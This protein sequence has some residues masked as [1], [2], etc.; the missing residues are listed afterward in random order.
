MRRMDVSLRD[1]QDN[2]WETAGDNYTVGRKLDGVVS[3]IFDFGAFIKFDD[4]IEGLLRTEDVDWT[5]ASLDLKQKFKKGDKLQVVVLSVDTHKEKLRLGIKQLSDNPFKTFSMNY[6]KGAPVTCTVK[7]ILDNGITVALQ[8][9]LEVY[10]HISNIDKENVSK[11][12][13]F[14]KVGDEIHAVVKFVDVAKSKIELSRKE[15][16]LKADKLEVEQFI[17]NETHD[18][19]HSMTMGS[20]L[21]D[22]FANIQIGDKAEEKKT[23]KKAKAEKTEK[24]EKAEDAEKPAKKTSKKKDKEETEE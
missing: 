18:G 16:L 3:S 5:E 19:S 2:P 6:P 15:F 14:V 13:D 10:I 11:I 22:Q 4:G 17:V 1:L 12:E 21:K 9:D 23:T 24:A 20:L 7:A 8:D